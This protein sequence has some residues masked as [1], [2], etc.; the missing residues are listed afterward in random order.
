MPLRERFRVRE[1]RDA[2]IKSKKNLLLEGLS[3][4]GFLDERTNN[5]GA[6]ME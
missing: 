6:K 5:S 3:D 2:I 1:E 4:F